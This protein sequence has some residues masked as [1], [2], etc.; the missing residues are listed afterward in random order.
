MKRTLQAVFLAVFAAQALVVGQGGE[1]QR[2]LSQLRAALG[3]EAKLA[4]VKSISVEGQTLRS[5]P[6]GTS[7]ASNGCWRRMVTIVG[8]RLARGKM[9]VPRMSAISSRNGNVSTRIYG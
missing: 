3:G 5:T 8:R 2:V 4:A 9:L 1:V 6:D 7:P